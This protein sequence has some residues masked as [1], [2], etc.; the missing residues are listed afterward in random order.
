M[1]PNGWCSWHTRGQGS[2]PQ[3][4]G[5]DGIQQGHRQSPTP[6]VDQP[7]AG[8]RLGTAWQGSSSAGKAR[9][10]TVGSKLDVR[11]QCVLAAADQLHPWWDEQGQPTGWGKRLSPSTWHPLDR[12][13]YCLTVLGPRY[14]KDIGK[15]KWVRGGGESF[16]DRQGLEWRPSEDRP[17]EQ[18]L[19]SLGEGWLWGNLT[20]TSLCLQGGQQGEKSGSLLKS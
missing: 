20:A 18:G 7:P 3:G 2:H 16:Q 9:G 10:V 12:I 1:S 13:Q 4:P 17:G 8:H 6:W 5:W 19:L 15:S 14:G 11:L